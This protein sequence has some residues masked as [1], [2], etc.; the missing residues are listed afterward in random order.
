MRRTTHPADTFAMQ[1]A[2]RSGLL[3]QPRAEWD[4]ELGGWVV[5]ARS[6]QGGSDWIMTR[7]GRTATFPTMGHAWRAADG[8]RGEGSPYLIGRR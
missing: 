8:L 6:C 5:L 7:Q 4:A 1:A 2:L 3:H